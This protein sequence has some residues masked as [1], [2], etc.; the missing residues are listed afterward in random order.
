MSRTKIPIPVKCKRCDKI[1]Y[2]TVGTATSDPTGEHLAKMIKAA[3]EQALCEFHAQQKAW[4]YSR[5]EEMR[6]RWDRGDM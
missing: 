1:V 6:K 2:V 3:T 5:G 4:F